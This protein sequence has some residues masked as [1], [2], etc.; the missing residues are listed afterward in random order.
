MFVCH[1]HL[2]VSWQHSISI[3]N[4][5]R[6][7]L[8]TAHKIYFVNEVFQTEENNETY[9]VSVHPEGFVGKLKFDLLGKFRY[10]NLKI[11]NSS[12][13]GLSNHLF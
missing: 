10:L 11:E 6:H 8:P 1:G 13:I 4:Y 5:Y 3:F 2:L 7:T 12:V 9:Y